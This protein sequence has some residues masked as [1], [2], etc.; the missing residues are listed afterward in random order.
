MNRGDRREDIFKD[1]KDRERFLFTAGETCAK[2]EW[3]VT[4]WLF[5]LPLILLTACGRKKSADLSVQPGDNPQSSD[6]GQFVTS[7]IEVKDLVARLGRPASVHEFGDSTVTDFL[8]IERSNQPPHTL[9]VTVWSKQ[10][11]V[12]K[13]AFINGDIPFKGT[14]GK[15]PEVNMRPLAVRVPEGAITLHPQMIY[16]TSFSDEVALIVKRA[17]I[18]LPVGEDGLFSEFT[19]TNV[20][21]QAEVFLGTNR[22]AT[23]LIREWIQ[24]NTV[25][26]DFGSAGVP[27]MLFLDTNKVDKVEQPH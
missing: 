17:L 10:G 26:L 2:T 4:A 12:Y 8:F 13:H 22:V 24:T 18:E 27:L 5:I 11:K 15:V 19:R 23:L 7:G 1:D 6:A 9:G 14:G 16:P 3:R 25:E 20:G 21:N